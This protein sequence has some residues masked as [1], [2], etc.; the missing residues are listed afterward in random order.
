MDQKSVMSP[1]IVVHC[2]QYRLTDISVDIL[3][4]ILT[5]VSTNILG[6]VLAKYR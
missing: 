5:D 4:D 1:T 3:S 2:Q 6:K